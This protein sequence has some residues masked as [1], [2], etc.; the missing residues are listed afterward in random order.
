MNKEIR[1]ENY[2]RRYAGREMP[3]PS[4]IDNGTQ[5]I[6]EQALGL[7]Q[8]IFKNKINLD[9]EKTAN[10]VNE[11]YEGLDEESCR[12]LEESD[13]QYGRPRGVMIKERAMQMAQIE[14]TPLSKRQ[15]RGVRKN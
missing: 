2:F 14:Q 6:V 10:L 15:H 3:L 9:R 4:D 13:P 7:W 5:Q 8:E 1:R 12:W 11:F